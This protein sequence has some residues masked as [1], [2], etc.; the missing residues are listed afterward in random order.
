MIKS[1][2]CAIFSDI[3]IGVHRDSDTWHRISLELKKYYSDPYDNEKLDIT[4]KDKPK[5]Y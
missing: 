4:S 5:F 3:H 2:N 1:S